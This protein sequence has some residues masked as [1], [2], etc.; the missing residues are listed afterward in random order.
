M[1]TRYREFNKAFQIPCLF[2]GHVYLTDKKTI[3]DVYLRT[4]I[5]YFDEVKCIYEL[6]MEKRSRTDFERRTQNKK[7]KI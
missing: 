4:Y 7:R 3:N 5:K 6:E 2:G 1:N